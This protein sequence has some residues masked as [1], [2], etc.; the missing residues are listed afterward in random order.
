VKKPS[1]SDTASLSGANVYGAGIEDIE[2]VSVSAIAADPEAF[3]GKTVRV[4]GMVTDVCAHRGLLHIRHCGQPYR[5][6][7]EVVALP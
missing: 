1:S 2:R 5:G 4:E 3:N 7:E 6:L